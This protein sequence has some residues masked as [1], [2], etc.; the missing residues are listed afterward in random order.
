MDTPTFRERTPIITD[1][2]LESYANQSEAHFNS[3]GFKKGEIIQAPANG[4]EGKIIMIDCVIVEFQ[5]CPV[6]SE[7]PDGTLRVKDSAIFLVAKG[8]THEQLSTTI[9][10]EQA[11]QYNPK[12]ST[13]RK[14]QIYFESN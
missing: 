13:N 9:T 1:R 10:P 8:F 12:G 3:L 5:G 4:P 14:N 11:K 6:F 2:Q 7:N